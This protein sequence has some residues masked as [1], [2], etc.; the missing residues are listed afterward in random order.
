MKS[1]HLKAKVLFVCLLASCLILIGGVS[2]EA[3]DSIK[4]GVAG[5]LKY[6]WGKNMVA[7]AQVAADELNASGGVTVNGKKFKIEIISADSND[8][9]SIVDAVNTLK[10]LITVDKAVSYTH[11]RAHET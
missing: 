10:R 4:I 7:G 3:K 8:Y 5:P 9:Q 11:L 1:E 6:S 2:T